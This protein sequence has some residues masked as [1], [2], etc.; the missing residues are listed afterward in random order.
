MRFFPYLCSTTGL[1][2][3]ALLLGAT[4]VAQQ[5]SAQTSA[6]P[7]KN[8]TSDRE[9]P[10]RQQAMQ[11]YEQHKLPAAAALLEK[12]VAR[13]PEDIVAHERLGV[14]LFSRAETQKELGDNSDLCRVLLA[15]IPEDGSPF[16][17]SD[18]KEV[19]EA[20]NRGEAAFAKGEWERAIKEYSQA[21]QLD[22]KSY[23]AAVA[24]GDTYFRLKQMDKAGEWFATAIQID[25]NSEVAYRYWGDALLAEGKMKEAREKFIQAVVAF[26]YKNSWFG[27]HNWVNRNNLKLNEIQ[28]KLPQAPTVGP[29]GD[30]NITIDPANLGKDKDDPAAAAWLFYP[31][32][33]ALWRGEKFAKEYPQEKSY[34]H[35]LKEEVSALSSVATVFE[36]S[37]QKKKVKNPD[38][39]LALLSQLK[40]E[41][42]LEAYVLLIL[43]D[44]GIAR[45]YAAYRTEHRSELFQLMDKYVVPPAR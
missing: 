2:L 10:E 6:I 31:M 43:P 29:K 42:L 18:R 36:E 32:Q 25:P 22:P 27:L 45:D 17:F 12:V 44:D 37:Q 16:V 24:L 7:Q 5:P 20:M 1:A 28:I 13:Y 40:S 41:G 15:E 39:S 23:L 34:R 9:D 19:D 38:A 14:A 26:P 33:R 21:L 8:V 30:I 11:L 35:S 4:A 3:A